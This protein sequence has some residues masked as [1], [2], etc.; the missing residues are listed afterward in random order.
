MTD[1][2]ANLDKPKPR[3]GQGSALFLCDLADGVPDATM[4]AKWKAGEYPDV[5]TD[6]ALGWRK[7][8]GRI[9]GTPAGRT[10]EK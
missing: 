10:K 6:Y 4:R 5:R 8:F 1:L 7:L 3:P 9:T 2:F